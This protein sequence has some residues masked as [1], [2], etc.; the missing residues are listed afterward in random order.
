MLKQELLSQKDLIER[1]GGVVVQAGTNPSPFEITEGI[2]TISGSDLTIA[3]ATEQ[4]V[5]LGKTFY[6]GSPELKTG[7]ANMDAESFHHVFMYNQTSQTYEDDIYYTCPDHLLVIKANM[8]EYNYNKVTMTFNQELV[9]ISEY[10][11][12]NAKNFS[13]NNFSNLTKLTRVGQYAFAGT[14]CNG[15][16]FGMLP[17]CL[18]RIDTYAFENGIKDNQSLKFPDSLSSL[19]QYAFRQSTRKF[20]NSFDASTCKLTSLSAYACYNLAFNCDFIV[21]T[22]VT[23]VL[24]QFNYNGCFRNIVIHASAKVSDGA[25]GGSSSRPLSDFFLQTVVCESETPPFLGSTVFAEQ[26]ISNGFKIYVPDN[27]VEEYKASTYLT[28]YVN[29]IYPM[30]QKE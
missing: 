14:G 18:A 9:T 1:R 25:F 30:S 7:S 6:A 4:D 2:K 23:S 15:I 27:A 5:R 28:K 17:N 11:F 10:A 3:T 29:C 20:L 8:F 19:G 16:D 12:R 21:P 24:N 13:F 26:N 22:Q